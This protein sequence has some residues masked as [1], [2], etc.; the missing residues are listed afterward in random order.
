MLIMT[1]DGMFDPTPDAFFTQAELQQLKVIL[2]GLIT[3]EET[4]REDAVYYGRYYKKTRPE[5][6]KN[7]YDV[8][9][10]TSKRIATLAKLQYKVKH[11]LLTLD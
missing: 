11:K 7:Y 6:A 8:A 9:K 1:E 3:A 4:Y 2:S 10:K 5:L